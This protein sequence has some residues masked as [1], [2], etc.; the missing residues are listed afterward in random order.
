MA[1]KRE[2]QTFIREFNKHGNGT[3]AYQTAY[4]HVKPQTARV[5]AYRLS[6]TPAVLQEITKYQAK[7][8]SMAQ[9]KAATALAGQ[10]VAD[11]LTGDRKKQILRDIAEGK[12]VYKTL[13]PKFDPETGKWGSEVTAVSEPSLLERLKAIELHNKMTGEFAPDKLRVDH[14]TQGEKVGFSVDFDAM[15][16]EILQSLDRYVNHT[17]EDQQ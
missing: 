11:I 5:E 12:L 15:P 6:K 17:T 2:W 10:M 9:K 13:A 8:D 16:V 3:R 14:T 7:I 4:P 1:L